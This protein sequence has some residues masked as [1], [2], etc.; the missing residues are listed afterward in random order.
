M[1]APVTIGDIEQGIENIRDLDRY[2][3]DDTLSFLLKKG[4]VTNE[5][6]KETTFE[7][8]IC[9]KKQ[10]PEPILFVGLAEVHA[11]EDLYTGPSKLKTYPILM[12]LISQ[13]PHILFPF[14]QN[15]EHIW[16]GTMIM[17]KALV[18][19]TT[20]STTTAL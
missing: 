18:Y 6:D 20:I 14:S 1:N 10:L 8:L 16:M 13:E 7:Q 12:I 17:K 2:S 9:C 4:I 3:L 15:D 11:K 19:T 5:F